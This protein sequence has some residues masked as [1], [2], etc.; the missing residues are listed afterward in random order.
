VKGKIGQ[1]LA[2]GLPVVT[3]PIGAE[4]MDLC[5]A[6]HVMIGSTP[7]AFARGVV[8]VYGDEA[9]WTRLSHRGRERVQARMGYDTVRRTV[10]DI[11]SAVPTSSPE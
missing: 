11:L 4:G 1:S 8:D 6:E 2:W 9:T 10:R 7:E 3:T 5:H